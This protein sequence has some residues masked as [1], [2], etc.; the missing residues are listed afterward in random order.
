MDFYE[1]IS[2]HYD[3][4]FPV[5]PETVDFISGSI[6][7]CSR[8]LDIACGTGGYSLALAEKGHRLTGIDLDR[9][10]ID[11]ARAKAEGLDLHTVFRVMDMLAMVEQLD[12]GF[13]LA[14]CI[15]NSLVHLES[16]ENIQRVLMDCQ[17]LLNP[18][19]TLVVQI[20]NYDRILAKGITS[21]PTLR[22]DSAG[23]EFVRTY[24]LDPA[25][26]IVIFRTE[27]RIGKEPGQRIVRNQVPLRILKSEDLLGLAAS[28]GFRDLQ[29]FGGFDEKPFGV[30]TLPLIL[31]GYK[32]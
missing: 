32:S 3:L 23:L 4:I 15:G 6:K 11:A 17:R 2:A 16:E 27:L 30:D 14:F 13:D 29:L 12:P 20:I 28:A 26:K 24:E 21:L 25:A 22:D 10:M 7:P 18:G 9:G 8:I 5:D 19:G 1:S 31:C